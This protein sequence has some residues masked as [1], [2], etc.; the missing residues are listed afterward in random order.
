[1]SLIALM[2]IG[3]KKRKFNRALHSPHNIVRESG[4]RNFPVSFGILGFGICNT[5]N[6]R[7]LD[8]AND[9]NPNKPI[10]LKKNLESAKLGIHNP[11]L[12][13]FQFYYPGASS[14]ALLYCMYVAALTLYISCN[15]SSHLLVLIV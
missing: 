7:N 5:L 8:P 13:W 3:I 15:R 11:R 2:L 1:M 4:F 10:P 9:W 14:I 12:S 6:S